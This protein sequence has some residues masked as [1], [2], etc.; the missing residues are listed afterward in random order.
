VVANLAELAVA[1]TTKRGDVLA[2]LLNLASHLH[3]FAGE[4]GR[5]CPFEL[6]EA[7]GVVFERDRG[8]F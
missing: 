5:P 3:E 4:H 6:L 2:D 8:A 7:A 1:L